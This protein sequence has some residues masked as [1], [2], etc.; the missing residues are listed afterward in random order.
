MDQTLASRDRANRLFDT[1]GSLLTEQQR[2]LLQ[3][4]YQRDH[5]LGEIAEQMRISRQAVHDG[6]RRALAAMERYEA[7]LRLIAGNGR[8]D[9]GSAGAKRAATAAR[10]AEHYFTVSPRS[11]P[12]ARTFT[13]RLRGRTWIFETAAG[14]FAQRGLDPGTRLLIETMRIGRRDRV[15]DLGCGYGPAGLVAA[16]LATQGAAWLVD[17]NHRAAALAAANAHRHRLTNVRVLVGDTASPVREGSMDVAITNPPIRAGRRVVLAF[18]EGAWRALRPG[19][20][21]YLVARTAQGAQTLGRL[22]AERFGAARQVAVSGGYRV[23]EATRP[24]TRLGS[25]ARAGNALETD[26]V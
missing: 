7:A 15:L 5:S 21:F 3:R 17:T 20:R 22:I 23:Y 16:A 11:R 8:R 13:V 18:I 1:Y 26:R 19:G 9:R 6:L 24:A 25:P 2:Q 14:V 4:Y 12:R 10:S